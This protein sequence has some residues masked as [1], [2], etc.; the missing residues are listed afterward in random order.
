MMETEK[1]LFLLDL[2]IFCGFDAPVNYRG[3]LLGTSESFDKEAMKEWA[4]AKKAL[5]EVDFLTLDVR[6]RSAEWRVVENHRE[7]LDGIEDIQEFARLQ[8]RGEGS[9]TEVPASMQSF[10]VQMQEYF[11]EGKE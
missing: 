9:L 6:V 4:R 1:T 5:H 11:N 7:A 2:F 3:Y 10:E 8:E